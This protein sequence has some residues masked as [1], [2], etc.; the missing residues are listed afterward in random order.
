MHGSSQRFETE[1]I[2]SAQSFYPLSN[3]RCFRVYPWD[4]YFFTI[5]TNLATKV[6]I[7]QRKK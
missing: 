1:E 3:V 6:P 5:G 7:N 4:I 2:E